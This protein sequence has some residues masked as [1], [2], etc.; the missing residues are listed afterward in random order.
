MVKL[1]LTALLSPAVAAL[2]LLMK[3]KG[4]GSRLSPAVKQLLIGLVFAAIAILSTELGPELNGA[5]I[6]SRDGI[7]LTAGLFFGG[8]SGM[9]AG[10]LSGLERLIASTWGIGTYSTVACV[11]STIATGIIAAALRKWVLHGERPSWKFALGV[12]VPLQVFHMTMIFVT[13]LDDSAAAVRVVYSATA[14]LLAA[15]SIPVFLTALLFSEFKRGGTEKKGDASRSILEIL[16]TRMLVIMAVFLMIGLLLTTS[17]G[18]DMG[19]D[20][21][22]QLLRND[23]SESAEDLADQFSIILMQICNNA[24]ARINS[25]SYDLEQLAATYCLKEINLTDRNGIVTESNLPENIGYDMHSDP[26]SASYLQLLEDSAIPADI[27]I[28]T[29]LDTE[30]I[31]ASI[32]ISL[33]EGLMQITADVPTLSSRFSYL[34]QDFANNIRPGAVG[35]EVLLGPDGQ[36]ISITKGY[37]F[38]S[39]PQNRLDSLEEDAKPTIV[40]INEKNYFCCCH[41]DTFTLYA[42]YPVSNTFLQSGLTIFLTSFLLILLFASIYICLRILLHRLVG[43]QVTSMADTL[44]EISAGNL[45][46][47][48]EVSRG[49]EFISLSRD[50]NKTVETLKHYIEEASNRI[51]AELKMAAAIQNA[52]LPSVNT[53]QHQRNDFAIQARMCPAKHVGGDFY[54]F[55]FTGENELN[56]S[57][58]DVS[59]KG[60]PAALFMMRSMATLRDLSCRDLPLEAVFTNG[61][62]TLCEGNDT[63][64]FVTA[65]QCRL[66]TDSGLVEYVNAG[67]NPPLLRK[68]GQFSYLPKTKGPFLGAFA[69]VSYHRETLQMQPGDV[70]LLYTDGIVEAQNAA[71]ELYGEKRLL[72]LLNTH[73]TDDM[74]ELLN[75]IYEDVNTFV[76]NAPQFDDMTL[77]ALQYLGECQS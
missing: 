30:S 47:T 46:R 1:I 60:I 27:Y 32:G 75:L 58:A 9:I 24:A 43:Q 70:L 39:L 18:I 8:P 3:R 76:G 56:L 23:L 77:V 10:T 17:L 66:Y 38:D 16:Q 61:N 44:S 51:D 57:I 65:W 6:S 59:G 48:I 33:D 55:Y 25:G 11:F 7:V 45:D 2:I 29:S 21:T 12:M 28:P 37:T 19:Y 40:T 74:Q 13:H 36:Y 72:Q 49:R 4:L 54:D 50:I 26:E 22:V 64:T 15:N 73:W 52:A 42:F 35:F 69:G 62:T 5:C 53:V 41:R 20:S 34:L 63:V 14:P 31:C 68:E 71:Y 67:H